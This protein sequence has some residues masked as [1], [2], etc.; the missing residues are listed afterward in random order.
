MPEKDRFCALCG[1]PLTI[2]ICPDP[3]RGTHCS[4]CGILYTNPSRNAGVDSPEESL[5]ARVERLELA[6]RRKRTHRVA[7]KRHI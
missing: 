2:V 7:P 6:A 1:H 5:L 3:G 4:K